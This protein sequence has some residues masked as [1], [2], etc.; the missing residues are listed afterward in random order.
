MRRF[1]LA[2]GLLIAVMAAVQVVTALQ[3]SQTYDEAVHLTAGYSYLLTGDYRLNVEH[4]PLG[5]ILSALPLL[6]LRPRLPLEEAS[7]ED[8]DQYLF[9]DSFL[10]HNRVA[11]DALLFLG[12]SMNIL[13]TALFALGLALWTR[14]EFGPG[15]AI[16]ALFFFTLDPN[17]IA[18]GRYVTTDL[19]AA[20]FFFL[21]AVTWA[22]FLERR[23]RSTVILAGLVFG[24]ALISK[25]S[26]LI[27]AP[28]LV[29]LYVLKWAQ[30]GEGLSIWHMLRSLAAVTAIA[31]LVVLIA[32]AP[33]IDSL[34][35]VYKV[36]RMLD[37]DTDYGPMPPALA[38]LVD[39]T[40]VGRTFGA[41]GRVLPLPAHSWLVGLY[42]VASHNQGGHPSYLL[43][44]YSKKGFRYYFPVVF[45]VK[46]PTAVL[47]L[48]AAAIPLAAAALFR[49]RWR[50]IPFRW[51][52]L[53][54]PAAVYFAFAMSSG[55]N[56]GVR[57]LLPFYP[58]LFILI[59][60]VILRHARRRVAVV[61]LAI[62]VPFQ[63]YES[64]RIYPYYL[65]FFNTVCGG[66]ARGH[67]Y[68]LD[69]NIDWGQDGK[70]TAA[71]FLS[72]GIRSP[73]GEYFGRVPLAYY[74]LFDVPIPEN[75]AELAD[76]DCLAFASV[77][78]LYGM[79]V[80]RETFAWLRERT[81][82]ARIGYSIYVYD[83]RRKR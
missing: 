31:W 35:V 16:L 7:W 48:L 49:R 9:A 23:R 83:L 25:Y 79:Y 22:R 11:A 14:R 57:H 39:N 66:P 72:R 4:P 51:V 24:L 8:R 27:L 70:R 19:I 76:L 73:C 69:S 60:A 53:A 56:I 18:H 28:L 52:A 38:T 5:K 6:L 61:L 3:E 21:T 20:C 64:A 59:A 68:V 44:Q 34:R 29:L 36:R 13:L 81:P 1:P 75:R 45:G 15:V 33:E 32:Y 82:I 55:I 71:W 41:I 10:Y 17:L 78:P 37:P 47:L 67:H 80:G 62:A 46:T 40:P 26:M 43:G 12:R 30:V 2:V 63:V 58:P 42:S 77:T 50:A 74:G 54:V 65:S